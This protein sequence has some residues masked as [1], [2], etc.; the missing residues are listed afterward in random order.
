[1]GSRMSRFSYRPLAVD[2]IRV[3]EFD[4]E[5]RTS[6]TIHVRIRHIKRPGGESNKP[7]GTVKLLERIP[8][9]DSGRTS[10]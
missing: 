10:C 2:E 6:P 5:Q 7:R 4:E 9:D 3:V 8:L 1:M